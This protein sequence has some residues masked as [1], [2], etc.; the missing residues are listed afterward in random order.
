LETR[1]SQAERK[2]EQEQWQPIPTVDAGIGPIQ[3]KSWKLIE[4]KSVEPEMKQN[5]NG[6]TFLSGARPL[7]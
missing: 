6:R 4:P 3:N 7:T 1:L 2:Q 5:A